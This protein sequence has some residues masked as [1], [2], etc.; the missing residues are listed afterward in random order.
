VTFPAEEQYPPFLAAA[1]YD[2][3]RLTGWVRGE[4][5]EQSREAGAEVLAGTAEQVTQTGRRSLVA[6]ITPAY[7]RR[8]IFAPGFPSTISQVAKL[9]LLPGGYLAGIEREPTSEPYTVTTLVGAD[10]KSGGWTEERLRAAGTDWPPEIVALY[11]RDTL[12]DGSLGPQSRALL[13]EIFENARSNNAYD[14]AIEI[15]DTLRDTA[16]FEYDTDLSD[17]PCVDTS[18]VECFVVGR[19]GFC[20]YYASTMTVFLREL[21]IPA[22]YVEGF[23]PGEPDAAGGGRTVRADDGH[24]W[25]QAYFPGY[26]WIDFDPTGNPNQPQ[27]APIPS[28]VPVAPVISHPL[29]PV[30][31]RRTSR[32]TGSAASIWLLPMP[33]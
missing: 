2:Q 32:V 18:I 11:G 29:G 19:A 10:E 20:Q 25:V 7:A 6:T 9:R 28:G 17:K 4:Q 1:Y 26:G 21:G 31:N 33:A 30:R 3:F 15:R 27:L 14:L 5:T 16:Q 22:R 24:A 23:L 12:P 8:E 13:A